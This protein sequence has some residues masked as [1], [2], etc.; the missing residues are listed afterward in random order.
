MLEL[1]RYEKCL[2]LWSY[3]AERFVATNLK[4]YLLIADLCANSYRVETEAD[5][6]WGR[7]AQAP[8][9]WLGPH[10]FTSQPLDRYRL[11]TYWLAP[12]PPRFFGLDPALGRKMNSDFRE[13]VRM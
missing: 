13:T 11:P 5:L 12:P 1:S 10:F 3:H 9:Y 2:L 7:E 6:R 8:T 4:L